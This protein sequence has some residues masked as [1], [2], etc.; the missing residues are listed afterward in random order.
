MMTE[1]ALQETI[2]RRLV[3][4]DRESKKRSVIAQDE[5]LSFPLPL[6]ILGEPGLGKSELAADIALQPG[7]RRIAAGSF[8]RNEFPE[9]LVAPGECLVIDGIDEI[10]SKHDGDGLE[11]ILSKLSR[12]ENP[13]FILLGRE[14]DWRGASDRIKVEDDFGHKLTELH[15]EPFDRN[16]AVEFLGTRFP[17]IDAEQLLE[18]LAAR[19][20]EEIY[21]NPLTLRL[22]GEVA[23]AGGDLPSGRAEILDRACRVML[24]EVNDRHLA[25]E[26]AATGDEALLLGAGAHAA[27]HLLGNFAGTFAG[28]EADLPEAHVSLRELAAL[29]VADAAGIALKTRLFKA[30]GQG[31]FAIVHRV[32]A[33]YLAAKWLAACAETGARPGRLLGLFGNGDR[34]PTSLRG[35]HAWLVHFSNVLALPAITADPYAVLRYGDAEGLSLDQARCLLDALKRLSDDDPFFRAEDWGRHPAPALLRPELEDEIRDL[36]VAPAGRTHLALLLLEAL[37]GHAMARRL[38]ATLGAIM[39]DQHRW[40]AERARASEA[41][42]SVGEL[43]DLEDCL[44]DLLHQADE[45]SLRLAWELARDAGLERIDMRLAAQIYLAH[46]GITFTGLTPPEDDL[47]LAYVGDVHLERLSIGQIEQWLDELRELAEPLIDG[48]GFSAR[49]QLID[50]TRMLILRRLTGDGAPRAPAALWRWISWQSGANGY[51]NDVDAALTGW[52]KAHVDARRALHFHLFFDAGFETIRDAMY[53]LFDIGFDLHP[54]SEDVVAL[55]DEA[56]RR[57]SGGPVDPELLEELVRLD[58]RKEGISAEVKARASQVGAAIEGFAD[59]LDSLA[60]PIVYEWQRKQAERAAAEED[61]SRVYLEKVREGLAAHASE[62]AGGDGQALHRLAQVYL[63]RTGGLSREMEPN[64]RVAQFL[65]PDLGEQVLQGFMAS[66]GRDDLPTGRAVSEQHAVGKTFCAELPL[67]CGIAERLRRGMSIAD[68]P[69]QVLATA[70]TAWRRCHQSNFI[71]GIEIGPALETVTLKDEEAAERYFRNSIEPSLEQACDSAV[72]LYGL[73]HGK[74]WAALAGRLTIE[75]L[76]RFPALPARMEAELLS[77]AAQHGSRADLQRLARDSREGIASDY[78]RMLGWLSLDF[79]VDFEACE[80]AL[81]AAARDDPEFLWFLRGRLSGTLDDPNLSVSIRQRQFIVACF[82]AAWPK[83]DRP[84]GV[85]HGDVHPWD[86][87]AFIERMIFAIAGDPGKEATETLEQLAE[88]V[89][90]S[91]RPAVRHALAQQRR[92]RADRDYDPVTIEELAAVTGNALPKSIDDMR[93]FFGERVSDANG[94]MHSTSTD[95]WEAYWAGAEPIEENRC[96]NR[97][98]E[99]ISRELPEAVRFVTEMNMPGQKRADI[100]AVLGRLGLPVEIKGQWHPDVWTAPVEQLAARYM[101][102]WNAEGRGVYIVL[103][104]GNMPGKNLPQHPAGLP[105]PTTPAELK[106]MLE[107]RLPDEL[108]PMIDV[109]V[110]DVSRPA[111]APAP[112]RRKTSREPKA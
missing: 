58:H 42:L 106:S 69:Q 19:G 90:E 53:D 21:R 31:R 78:E 41:L 33:E 99:H 11:R 107:D 89:D 64:D 103:W 50:L 13:R 75:W 28:P 20:L 2:S 67:V 36:V 74:S 45:D 79:L 27:A 77:C 72:D 82:S 16:D 110:V 94:R 25:S 3:V 96:R 22:M 105:R 1:G 48:A 8:A 68:L 35:L 102:D 46:L 91:Y 86:A 59:K 24:R 98:V 49:S 112:S 37:E 40:Y 54:S 55:L 15:L 60:A 56:V 87:A 88:T 26:H 43:G 5:L 63:G 7:F 73:A 70:L 30:E 62:I 108:R 47:D 92:T 101:H 23:R 80:D 61:A 51:R 10:A 14:A 17:G 9:K 97:L 93:I 4:L 18:H 111:S 95:M 76:Q 104:F 71:G 32:I 100:A 66:L 38:S 12:I 84:T 52:F 109:H 81:A 57:A 65:G 44:R 29:P 39:S 85:T 83:V 6:I 34:V